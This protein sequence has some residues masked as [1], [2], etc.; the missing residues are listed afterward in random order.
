MVKAALGKKSVRDLNGA[1][2]CFLASTTTEL[3]LTSY[4]QGQQHDV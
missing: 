2:V 3:N 4:F 1:T